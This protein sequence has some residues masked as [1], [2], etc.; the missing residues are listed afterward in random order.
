M[1][2]RIR[3]SKDGTACY[4]FKTITGIKT[5][6]SNANMN[7]LDGDN[8]SASTVY[9]WGAGGECLVFNFPVPVN[10]SHVKYKS[11]SNHSNVYLEYCNDTLDGIL[12]T[13][14][15]SAAVW[16]QIGNITPYVFPNYTKI[17]ASAFNVTTSWLRIRE[18][19]NEGNMFCAHVFGTY[20]SSP[21]KFVANDEVTELNTTEYP[22]SVTL[23]NRVVNNTNNVFKI[24]NTSG[25]NKAYTLSVVPLHYEG[26]EVVNTHVKLS[27]NGGAL[28]SS[29]TTAVVNN[30]T[31]SLPITLNTAFPLAH[32]ADGFHHFAIDVTEL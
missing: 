6:L 17:D 7:I 29:V 14:G 22:L 20:S 8:S 11:N 5:A 10:I 32:A 1:A 19:G 24:K 30:N 26:D 23:S 21:Y 3:Y 15:T 12:N 13:A 28:A 18:P 31:A 4:G 25:V 9:L 27:Y 16:T 2:T